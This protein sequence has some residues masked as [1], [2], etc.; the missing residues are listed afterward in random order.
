MAVNSLSLLQLNIK[1]A[2][3]CHLLINKILM[4]KFIETFHFLYFFSVINEYKCLKCKYHW[5]CMHEM[6]PRV[7]LV[8]QLKLFEIYVCYHDNKICLLIVWP[9]GQL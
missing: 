3:Y 6:S 5:D 4:I 7:I 1:Y 8:E 9:E 2:Q